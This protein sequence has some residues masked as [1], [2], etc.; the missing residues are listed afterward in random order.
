MA[1]DKSRKDRLALNGKGSMDDQEYYG[2]TAAYDTEIAIDNEEQDERE[3][4][5]ARQ[6]NSMGEV[7]RVK[8][9]IN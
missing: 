5:V 7:V 3:R 1:D 2:G 8:T 4:A 9:M 6:V